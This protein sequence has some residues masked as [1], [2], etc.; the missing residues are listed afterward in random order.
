MGVD[1]RRRRR[2]LPAGAGAKG[3]IVPAEDL[4]RPEAVY[5]DALHKGFGGQVAERRKR[6]V[7]DLAG[8]QFGHAAMFL[9]AG[10]DAP[11]FQGIAF[12]QF[13]GEDGRGEPGAAGGGDRRPDDRPMPQ[14][15]PVKKTQRHRTAMGRGDRLNGFGNV[16]FHALHLVQVLS[17]SQNSFSTRSTPCSTTASPRKPPASSYTR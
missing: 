2:E 7:H 9:G 15:D 11:A 8:A 12:R 1:G 3:E 14:V 16:Q 6:R 5:Q 17:L 10:E 4:P 13:E